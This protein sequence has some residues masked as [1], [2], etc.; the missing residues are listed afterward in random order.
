[1][2]WQEGK[3]I[4]Y[5]GKGKPGFE[6]FI[7]ELPEEKEE[8]DKNPSKKEITIAHDYVRL[9]GPASYEMQSDEK[10]EYPYKSKFGA[11]NYLSSRASVTIGIRDMV[12]LILPLL[13]DSK[14]FKE[15]HLKDREHDSDDTSYNTVLKLDKPRWKKGDKYPAYV[16][17]ACIFQYYDS[18]TKTSMVAFRRVG[19]AHYE[20]VSV[21]LFNT[22]KDSLALCYSKEELAIK[23]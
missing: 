4:G 19:Q 17:D 8:W 13:L 3:I 12:R 1:M 11:V 6:K 10:G 20:R 18:H 9:H 21:G 7:L 2:S 15:D 5:L 22:I 16:Y 23:E 14:Y